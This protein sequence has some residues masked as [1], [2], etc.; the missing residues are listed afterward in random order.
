MCC[1]FLKSCLYQ[2]TSIGNAAH[3]KYRQAG[4]PYNLWEKLE[5]KTELP[6]E[7]DNEFLSE[8]SVQS[9]LSGL[10]QI[11]I[12]IWNLLLAILFLVKVLIHKIFPLW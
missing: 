8:F 7:S 1:S 2:Q 5:I 11:L 10:G 4:N 3:Q 9:G 6:P 12:L